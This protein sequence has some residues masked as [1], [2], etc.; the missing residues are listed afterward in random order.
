M[1]HRAQQ[2]LARL[3]HRNLGD[4]SNR[5]A[6]QLLRLLRVTRL[7]ERFHQHCEKQGSDGLPVHD[8]RDQTHGRACRAAG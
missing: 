8:S 7:N 6:R 1:T 3:Q 2:D 4:M 5:R